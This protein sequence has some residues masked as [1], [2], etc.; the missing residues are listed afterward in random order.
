M[1]CLWILYST[2]TSVFHVQTFLAAPVEQFNNQIIEVDIVDINN[3]M[4]GTD[5]MCLLQLLKIMDI[6]LITPFHH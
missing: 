3:I 5:L 6:I 1:N 2:A 4:K